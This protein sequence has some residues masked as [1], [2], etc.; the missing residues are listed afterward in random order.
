M[1]Q[2]RA[3]I[4]ETLSLKPCPAIQKPLEVLLDLAGQLVGEDDTA[5]V[6][7]VGI[8]RDLA[9]PADDDSVGTQGKKLPQRCEC[10]LGLVSVDDDASA[11]ALA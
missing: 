9:S 6:I 2:V 1:Q 11:R 8:E 5:P 10:G 3:A 7:A 4:R